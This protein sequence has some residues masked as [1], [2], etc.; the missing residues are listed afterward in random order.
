MQSR[1]L[2]EAGEVVSSKLRVRKQ[3]EFESHCKVMHAGNIH[4]GD[5]KQHC[6]PYLFSFTNSISL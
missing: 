4:T 3:Y 5:K 6:I 1:C 2:S